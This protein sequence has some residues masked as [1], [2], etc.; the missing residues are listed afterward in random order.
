ML[1]KL[2]QKIGE[3]I[4]KSSTVGGGCI[5]QS[6]LIKIAKGR[7]FFV[8]RGMKNSDALVCE[9]TN[10]KAL[11]MTDTVRV[12]NVIFAD[13]EFL[14]LEYISQK[15]PVTNFFSLFGKQLAEMHKHTAEKFGFHIDNYIGNTKQINTWEES[16]EIFY[17]EHRLRF[18]L[19]SLRKNGINS[20]I[21]EKFTTNLAT[22]CHIL[23][24]DIEE[25]PALI[26]GDLWSG[27]F[28]ADEQGKPCIFDA[29][30]HYA[31]RE[32]E[33][34]MTKL[35][36]GFP[37]TFYESY[38]THF[39]LNKGYNER[40]PIYKLYHILNHTNLFGTSYLHS[41]EQIAQAY[42]KKYI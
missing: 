14:V 39:P 34:A 18:Q 40:E 26:H 22:I 35:F 36:G 21:L 15:T 20:P 30:T 28:M 3:E 17:R 31:H 16:W 5:A 41:A 11:A 12:P 42:M 2:S 38:N 6:F 7:S 27:N 13:E 25:P 29:T 1:T 8:K 32:A 4:V 9:A 10:L 33:L 23:L 37:P 24:S 19:Q